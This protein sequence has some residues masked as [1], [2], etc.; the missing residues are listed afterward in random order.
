M[1]VGGKYMKQLIE[2]P[3]EDGTSIVMEVD[4][5]QSG[6]Q[7]VARPGEIV[8]RASQTFET[9]MDNLKSIAGVVIGKVR[10][11]KESPDEVNVEFGIKFN[12]NV[13][14]VIAS[15]DSEA[16]LKVSLKWKRKE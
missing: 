1:F 9:A 12:G 8:A 6:V 11:L 14:V 4:E 16:T 3:M 7:R 5:S 10:A 15:V 13:G 2:I